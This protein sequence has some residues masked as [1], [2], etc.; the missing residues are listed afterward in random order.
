MN[1]AVPHPTNNVVRPARRKRR[2]QITGIAA[3]L[4]AT[5]NWCHPPTPDIDI[6]DWNRGGEMA[7]VAE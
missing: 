2:M 1:E 4:I 6:F 7:I 5:A 3:A